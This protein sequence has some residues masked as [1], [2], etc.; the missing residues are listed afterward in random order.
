MLDTV[1]S[2]YYAT[3]PRHQVSRDS[4]L[5]QAQLL[6]PLSLNPVQPRL[7][8]DPLGFLQR[9]SPSLGFNEFTSL[10]DVR[11]PVRLTA[12][13]LVGSQD[14]AAGSL[15]LS[16]VTG[17]LSYSLGHFHYE[18]DGFRPNNFRNEDISNAFVQAEL[19]SDASVMA[20]FRHTNSEAGSTRVFFWDSDTFVNDEI[21]QEAFVADTARV[22]LR[23]R[24]TPSTTVIGTYAYRDF[25]DDLVFSDGS[26]L[27]FGERTT[28]GE[29]RVLHEADTL[30]ATAGLGYLQ[31]KQET[32]PPILPSGPDT[33]TDNATRT[34]ML[35]RSPP[36]LFAQLDCLTI[37]GDI[38]V[39]REQVNPKLACPG[40]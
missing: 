15:T 2:D 22:G 13:G 1:L 40:R 3:R 19:S 17:R 21:H 20:E 4:E 11:R 12:D 30:A 28:N 18:T 24:L 36:H 26:G 14:T 9:F 37:I 8:S 5:L 34:F 23:Y 25:D 6:Q 7:A 39:D 32:N 16:G 38:D 10:L 29:L 31:L 27:F 35:L 33:T